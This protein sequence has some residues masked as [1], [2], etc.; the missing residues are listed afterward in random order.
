MVDPGFLPLKT[1]PYILA[2]VSK[3]RKKTRKSSCGK[4][5]EAYRP[6]HNLSK[7]ILSGGGGTYLGWGGGVPTL[8]GVPTL[9]YPYPDL[10]GRGGYLPW[11][12]VTNMRGQ[13]KNYLQESNLKV[14]NIS[15]WTTLIKI[16]FLVFLCFQ[17]SLFSSA[18]K[19]NTYSTTTNAIKPVAKPYWVVPQFNLLQRP[20]DCS[21][22][23]PQL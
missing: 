14:E 12:G 20:N 11:T 17:L 8:D 23:P 4:P 15:G 18:L 16:K 3:N 10:A 22:I 6:R 5:Q 7:H 21:Y 19:R 13:A 2:N 1:Q 9:G